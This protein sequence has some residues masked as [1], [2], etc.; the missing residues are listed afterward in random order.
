MLRRIARAC[1]FAIL[2][3]AATAAGQDAPPK[4]L[5]L[6][7]QGPDGH[8][9]QTHEYLQGQELLARLL[10]ET[11][12]LEVKVVH[13]DEPWAEGPELLAKADGVVMYLS[14]GAKWTQADPRR[15][16]ALLQ[17]A[18]RGGGIVG[19]HWGTGTKDAAN[20][21]GYLR[22]VGGCHGGP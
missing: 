19:L 16:D 13:A 2:L 3:C 6:L 8:P 9:P 11:P 12:G 22:L 1:S 14:E 17:L 10:S 15:F 21:A 18:Q 5:L 4:R 20:I 7:T